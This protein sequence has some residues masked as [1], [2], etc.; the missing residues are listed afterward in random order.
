MRLQSILDPKKSIIQLSC[1][2]QKKSL[3]IHDKDFIYH[4][5]IKSMDSIERK[6]LIRSLIGS[7]DFTPAMILNELVLFESRSILMKNGQ[8]VIVTPSNSNDHTNLGYSYYNSIKSMG[9]GYLYVE[10]YVKHKITGAYIAH[11]WNSDFNGNHID[12][13]YKDPEAF[14]Y[15]GVVVPEDTIWNIAEKNKFMIYAVLPFV[16]KF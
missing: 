12:F 2:E 6:K 15:F 11:S 3:I 16:R 8:H 9:K 7:R 1:L 4:D 5:F 14:E 10:G 13:T